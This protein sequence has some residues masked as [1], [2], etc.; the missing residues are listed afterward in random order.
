[1]RTIHFLHF[2]VAAP[3]DKVVGRKSGKKIPSQANHRG[4]T[5]LSSV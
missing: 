3:D 2:L 1:M 4:E 5:A